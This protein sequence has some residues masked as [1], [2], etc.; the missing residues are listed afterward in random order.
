M[1]T[2]VNVIDYPDREHV[3][4]LLAACMYPDDEK[5]N[6]QIERYRTDASLQLFGKAFQ[7]ELVGLIGISSVKSGEAILRHIAVKPHL[8]G[9]GIGQSMINE[10]MQTSNI[11]KLEAETD[12]D[13]VGFYQ[14][15]G[16]DITSLGEKY[17]GVERFL[18]ILSR[19]NMR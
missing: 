12:R 13:A 8:R 7:E 16:F 11:D 6:R 14:R 4:E 15:T 9:R 2:L 3:R 10:F 1:N 5:I 19:D 17:P 18:C